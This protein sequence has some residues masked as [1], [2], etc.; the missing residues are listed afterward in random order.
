MCF[1]VL[2]AFMVPILPIALEVGVECTYPVPEEYSSG[3][4]MLAGQLFGIAFTFAMPPLIDLRSNWHT[5]STQFTA[6]AIFTICSGV[7][8]AVRA[9]H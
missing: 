1:G 7:V 2:G 3:V 9:R 5:D 8:G 6:V 4:L